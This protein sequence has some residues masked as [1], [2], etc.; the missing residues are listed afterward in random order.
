MFRPSFTSSLVREPLPAAGHPHT[1][2]S[3]SRGLAPNLNPDS[4]IGTALGEQPNC[5]PVEPPR[6]PPTIATTRGNNDTPLVEP[7]VLATVRDRATN[8]GAALIR[9]FFDHLLAHVL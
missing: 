6:P 4:H 2:S 5:L 3:S 8:S 9:T 7:H 1:L